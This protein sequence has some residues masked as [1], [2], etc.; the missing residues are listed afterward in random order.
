MKE[1]LFHELIVDIEDMYK[2]ALNPVCLF[3]FLHPFPAFRTETVI[4]KQQLCEICIL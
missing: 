1:Q 2:T 3:Q 4:I